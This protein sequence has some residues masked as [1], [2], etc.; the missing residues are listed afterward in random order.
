MNIVVLVGAALFFLIT[1]ETRI[2]RHRA[3]R[4]LHVFAPSPT[5]STCIS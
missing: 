4:D 5:S 3:L 2:K 1:L